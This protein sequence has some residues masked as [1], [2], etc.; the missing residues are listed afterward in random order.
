MKRGGCDLFEGREKKKLKQK[1]KQKL[2]RVNRFETSLTEI[3]FL[4]PTPE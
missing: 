4:H 1:V 2:K 3:E